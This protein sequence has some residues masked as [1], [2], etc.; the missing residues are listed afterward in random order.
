[1]PAPAATTFI[2]NSDEHALRKI[3][4]LCVYVALTHVHV[5]G[6]RWMHANG[7]ASVS[8]AMSNQYVN[9]KC[10]TFGFVY[11]WSLRLISASISLP[12]FLSA[13]LSLSL[14]SDLCITDSSRF[15]WVFESIGQTVMY[16]V[17]IQRIISTIS[18]LAKAHN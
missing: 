11:V 12:L 14:C 8:V 13:S 10:D 1:M 4:Y 7:R 16:V 3:N 18:A 2:A 6:V 15:G 17:A 5:C 9:Y